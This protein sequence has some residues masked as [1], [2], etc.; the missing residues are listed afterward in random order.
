MVAFA[1]ERLPSTYLVNNDMGI[2]DSLHNAFLNVLVGQGLVGFTVLMI[3]AV[4]SA[5]FVLRNILRKK[6][7][8]QYREN[9]L[10]LAV[11][12]SL[13]VSMLFVG[14]ILYLNSGAAFWFWNI[15]GILMF[16]FS[17]E[18]QEVHA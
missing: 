5:V 13:A 14:D 11:V 1:Q 7:D 16:Y 4:L 12:A 3:F 8:I 6:E 15:L 18:E 10:L 17:E 9:I 2:F